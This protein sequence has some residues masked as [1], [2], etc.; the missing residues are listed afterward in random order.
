[1]VVYA[2]QHRKSD[3][4]EKNINFTMWLEKKKNQFPRLPSFR[5]CTILEI[6]NLENSQSFC[7]L[8]IFIALVARLKF[9]TESQINVSRQINKD[10][11]YK[12]APIYACFFLNDGFSIDTSP[13]KYTFLRHGN[14][15]NTL[16]YWKK[17][18][19]KNEKMANWRLGNLRNLGNLELFSVC[20]FPSFRFWL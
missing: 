11:V 4:K 5:F 10:A 7:L 15:L 3:L 6:E 19:L 18:F 14:I 20:L 8:Q 16:E 1:M 17:F 2:T 13:N 12:E 9:F